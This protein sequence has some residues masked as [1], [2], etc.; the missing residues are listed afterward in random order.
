MTVVVLG[1][2]RSGT[3]AVAGLLH[4]AGLKVGAADD[5][6]EANEGNPKGHYELRP[7]MELN[8]TI[9]KQWGGAWDNPPAFPDNWQNSELALD[10]IASIRAL[11]AENQLHD[12]VIKDPRI[13]VLLPLWSAALGDD[14]A[15]VA[16]YRHPREVALSLEVRDSM[17]IAVGMSLWWEYNYAMIHHLDG[18]RTYLLPYHHLV[19]SPVQSSVFL[20]EFLNSWRPA[21]D[22]HSVEQAASFIEPTLWR[23]QSDE[24]DIDDVNALYSFLVSRTGA[25]QSWETPTS[26]PR[27]QL[28]R[29]LLGISDLSR[30]ERKKSSDLTM[31]LELKVKELTDLE[32]RAGLL[33]AD[34][35]TLRA[36]HETLQSDY[37]R[38]GEQNHALF[39]EHQQLI[40]YL[41]RIRNRWPIRLVIRIKRT[42]TRH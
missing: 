13:T 14:A 30:A 29:A 1:M 37:I 2:H 36:D 21:L 7:M 20:A 10:Q 26:I 39:I 6:I 35:E 24:G 38:L 25:H 18:Y 32:Q 22:L 4:N 19:T 33:R 15:Y 16:M 34:H 31:Q 42:L 3:S 27:L 23:N 40:G 5:L 17:P 8:D 41:E 28:P 12:W 11:I 9:L